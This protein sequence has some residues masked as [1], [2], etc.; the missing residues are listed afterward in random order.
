MLKKNM[1]KLFAVLGISISMLSPVFCMTGTHGPELVVIN[2]SLGSPTITAAGQ[3]ALATMDQQ[4]LSANE[5]FT[6]APSLGNNES[7]I[8]IALTTNFNFRHDGDPS[9]LTV[10]TDTTQVAGHN[11]AFQLSSDNVLGLVDG[12]AAAT[13][14]TCTATVFDSAETANCTDAKGSPANDGSNKTITFKYTNPQRAYASDGDSV[15][16]RITTEENDELL[17]GTYRTTITASVANL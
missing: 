4:S 1:C 2:T 12:N 11:I 17:S 5:F 6:I 7:G 8:G 9:T 16:Y 10:A 15:L 13:V 3:T 14:S